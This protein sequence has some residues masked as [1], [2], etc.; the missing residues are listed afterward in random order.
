MIKVA[1][2]SKAQCIALIWSIVHTMD[3]FLFPVFEERYLHSAMSTMVEVWRNERLVMEG[4]FGVP[5]IRDE[6]FYQSFCG[7]HGTG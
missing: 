4:V 3:S 1:I 2:S 6:A 5:T 7:L